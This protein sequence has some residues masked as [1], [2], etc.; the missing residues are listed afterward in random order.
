ML[1]RAALYTAI[2]AFGAIWTAWAAPILAAE[3]NPR[4]RL[5]FD[6]AEGKSLNSFLREGTVAAHLVLRSGQDPRILVAFP[7]GNSGVGLW[8]AHSGV[9]MVWELQQWPEAVVVKDDKGRSLY[10][11]TASATIIGPELLIQRAVLSSVRVLREYQNSGA[12]PAEVNT[13]PSVKGSKVEWARDRLDGAAG[14]RL[15]LEVTHGQ[16]QG[17]R[18]IA[19]RDGRIG[20]TIMALSGE[21]PLTPLSGPGLLS[22]HAQADAAARNTLAFLSYQ[23]KFLAG[24]WRFN[25]YFGRDT[26]MSVCLLMPALDPGAVEDGLNSVLARLSP[27]GEVAHEEDIG[28]F[29]IL[30]HMRTDGTKSDAPVFDYKMIDANFMLAPVARAW[31]VEDPRGR[32]GAAPFLARQDGRY[33]GVPRLAGSDLVMNMRFVIRRAAAFAKEPEVAH[34]IGLKPGYAAGQW[35]DSNDG[36]GGGRYPYDVNAVLVP[37][38]LEAASR[39]YASGL[40]DPYLAADDRSLFSKAAEMARIWRERAPRLFE[41]EEPN[42]GARIAIKTY[43]AAVGVS[44][45]AALGSI[46]QAPERFHALAL[47]ADGNPVPVVNSDEG[48]ELLW[49]HPDPAALDEAVTAIMRPFPAG[50]LTDAGIVVANPVFASPEL[51][52]RFTNHAYHG[53][54]VWSWQQAMLA[55]ALSRQLARKDLA[56]S[57]R[58]RLLNAQRQLWRVIEAGKSMRN[59]ELWSW[60]YERGQF[61]IVPFGASGADADESNAAQ[62]WSTVYLGIPEPPRQ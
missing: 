27:T 19:G 2:C 34:L 44:P 28:E 37:A 12:A 35:R 26:L 49:G 9:P 45:D 1:I 23:D 58:N 41:V 3:A 47:Q 13:N 39:F 46:G 51:Q 5:S 40:L 21:T 20:V 62:L 55:A 42:E 48:F 25:T 30:D 14:Y 36:L 38:A 15:T 54:V 8:F 52:A 17:D 16:L 50:L 57:V 32:P 53:T 7:A 29:A 24:S 4:E 33:G 61:R 59:S 6:V 60:T 11:I 43:S 10:G 18:I 22:S 56:D 31:L